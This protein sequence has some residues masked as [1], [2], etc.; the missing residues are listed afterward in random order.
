M[1]KVALISGALIATPF[2]ALAQDLTFFQTLITQIDGL[3]TA[4]VPVV[5][6]LAILLFLWGLARYMLNQDDAEARAGARSIMLWGVVIIFVM[7]ALWGLVNLLETLTG[8]G[9]G[10]ARPAPALP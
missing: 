3:I 4:A 8:V 9:T 6:G 7:I 10:T 2:V 1:K 5:I